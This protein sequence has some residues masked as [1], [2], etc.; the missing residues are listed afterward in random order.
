MRERVALAA[1]TLTITAGRGGTG[2]LISVR[3]PSS[4]QSVRAISA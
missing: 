2:T 1:G 3:L 4:E